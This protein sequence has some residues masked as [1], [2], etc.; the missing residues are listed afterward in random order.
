MAWVGAYALLAT[1]VAVVFVAAILLGPYRAVERSDYMTYHVAA[2]IVL[3]GDG[4]C[5]Y[6]AQCQAEAQRA[7]IGEEPTFASGALPFNSPPWLAAVIAPLG[8]LPLPVG[9]GIFTLAG[10]LILAWGTWGAAGHA[11]LAG[12]PRLLAVVLLLTSWPTVMA[13]IRGQSTLM[14]VGLLGLS[15]GLAR[16]RSGLALGLSLMKPTLAPL[17]GTWQLVGGHWRALGAAVVVGVGFVLL[18]ALVISPDVLVDY[19]AH[20]FAV[21]GGDAL[22]VH[23][24]EMV[25]WRGA[26]D[27]LGVGAWFAVGGSVA[28]LAMVVF[29]WLRAPSRYLAASVAFL[30]TPL[31]LPHA[32]QHE[33]VLATVGIVLAVA[34][35]PT[36]RRRSAT[37]A[38][39]LHPVLWAGVALDAQVIAWLFFGIELGWLL[40]VVW[41]SGA[42]VQRPGGVPLP[43][44]FRE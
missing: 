33:F 39:V 17:W 25:N 40:V 41:I 38:I 28:T 19:P 22:G 1:V 13:V 30:A 23:S 7:L 3:Q 42:R 6:D 11:G 16:Y 36:L 34:A 44:R 20:L 12:A 2:R 14:V 31:V 4:A 15:V 29:A 18:S 24:A 21:A 26:G 35:V 10:L 9:F 8:E 27:R 37:A 5:L 43:T 32:N